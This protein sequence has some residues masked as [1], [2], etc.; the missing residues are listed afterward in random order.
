MEDWLRSKQFVRSRLEPGRFQR[1]ARAHRNNYID[2]LSFFMQCMAQ[3]QNKKRWAEKTPTHLTHMEKLSQAFPNAKFIH[4]IRDGRDV[5]IS[6]RKLG[7]AGI[8]SKDPLKQL[9]FSALDWEA[10]V[11]NGRRIGRTL[12]RNYLEFHYEDLVDN[13]E[14]MLAKI[15]DF[16][17]LNIDRQ[18][19]SNT[20]V[21]SLRKGNT[22][23][24]ETM[25]G[26]SSKGVG[27]WKEA[28]TEEELT[29]LHIAIGHTLRDLGYEAPE[30]VTAARFLLYWKIRLIKLFYALL[31]GVKKFMKQKLLIGRFLP[32]DL[33]VNHT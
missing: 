11:R 29:W 24:A 33:E 27:R 3:Q 17:D 6:R 25:G 21:G 23:F 26:I 8:R 16:A 14:G 20:A 2:F 12:G 15:N 13:V 31:T 18:S 1:E 9:L 5:A 28:L 10:T 7:W 19:M 4:I 32:T 22:A 30:N